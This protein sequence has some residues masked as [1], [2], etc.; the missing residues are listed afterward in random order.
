MSRV[1]QRNIEWYRSL[2]V[3]RFANVG[4]IEK[5]YEY[6]ASSPTGVTIGKMWRRHNGVFDQEF[7]RAGGI[8]KWVICRYEE[9]PPEVERARGDCKVPPDDQPYPAPDGHHW[10]EMART[11]TYRPIVC[12]KMERAHEIRI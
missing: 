11:V 5:L 12:V 1:E 10:V 2:P 8:P 6:S 7:I 4:Y 9:A 3:M